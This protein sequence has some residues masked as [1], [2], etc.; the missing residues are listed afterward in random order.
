M[1]W[2]RFLVFAAALQFW[3]LRDR[4]WQRRLFVVTGAVLAF[5][6]LD[7]FYQLVFDFRYIC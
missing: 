3:A 1:P 6:A 5:V 4:V 2:F 7:T